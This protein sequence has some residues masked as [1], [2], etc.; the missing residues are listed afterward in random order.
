MAKLFREHYQQAPWPSEVHCYHLANTIDV[1]RNQNAPPILNASKTFRRSQEVYSAFQRL[2]NDR[3]EA[4]ERYP[5]VSLSRVADVKA[6][7]KA[8]EGE[9]KFLLGYP[10]P[11]IGTRRGSEWHKAA[12]L[13]ARS[14]E[15]AL[16]LVTPGY[17]NK[18]ISRSK[19]GPFVLVVR[20]ALM[21]AGLK[22][23]TPEAIAAVLAKSGTQL[24]LS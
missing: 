18:R 2:M 9:K 8:L 22:E 10:D 1:V 3:L 7:R 4:L 21:L 15:E 20:D 23:R 5:G 12:H 24:G 6:L 14:V 13:I 16:R 17:R 11:E 19:H